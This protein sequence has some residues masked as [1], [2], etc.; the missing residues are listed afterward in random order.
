MSADSL[1]DGYHTVNPFIVAD[2]AEELMTFLAT[3]LRGVERERITRSDGRIGHAEMQIGDSVVMLTDATEALPARPGT[4]YVYVDDVD[5]AYTRAIGAGGASRSEPANQFY[6][7]REAGIVDPWDNIWWIATLFEE[8]PP[9]SLQ[10]RYEA[11][12]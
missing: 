7:N 5:D 3:V 9:Q 12:P 1:P 10:A 6:G 4:F 8:V 2:G 11:Q